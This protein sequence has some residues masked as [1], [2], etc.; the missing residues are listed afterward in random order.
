MMALRNYMDHFWLMSFSNAELT[1][2]LTSMKQIEDRFN[3]HYHY[4]WTFLNDEPFT[5]EFKNHTTRMASGATEYGLIPTEQWSIPSWI[6]IDKYQETLVRMKKQEVIYGD[7]TSYRH[8]CRYNSG[9]FWRHEIMM[10]YDWLV[11]LFSLRHLV[12]RADGNGSRYW[13]VEP[14]IGFYC[15]QTYDPFTF[16]RENNK[17]YSFV[18]TLP[19]YITTVETLWPATQEFA[20]LHPELIAKNNSLGFIAEDPSKEYPARHS[21]PYR[22]G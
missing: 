9:F 15:D 12:D 8:M 4:P 18:I 10:K 20:K 13:R 2:A 14:S 17:R 5:E 21:S 6:H 22:K 16:M 11:Y 19:E 3:R 7:S 1:D